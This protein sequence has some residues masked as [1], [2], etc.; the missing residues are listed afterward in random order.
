MVLQRMTSDNVTI[1]T[2]W[3]Y[4][5][6]NTI[7]TAKVSNVLNEFSTTVGDDGKWMVEINEPSLVGSGYSIQIVNQN[8]ERLEERSTTLND[9]AFGDVWFCSG[10][11]NMQWLVK[12]VRNAAMEMETATMYEDIRLLKIVKQAS[13]EPID[14]PLGFSTH[15]AKPE[16][17]FL[18]SESF[19][20]IC[21]FF[22]EQIYDELNVPIG[23]IDASVGGTFIEAWSPPEALAAC[24]VDDDGVGNDKNHNEYLWNA[25]IHPFLNM[26]IKGVL[27]YQGENNAGYSNSNYRGHNRDIYDCTFSNLIT[28]WRQ[29]WHNSDPEFPFGFVQLAPYTDQRTY[30]AWPQLRW[31]QTN[32]ADA[33]NNVFMAT[34][35]DDDFNLHPKNKRLPA[36]RLGWAAA[37]MVYDLQDR[38]LHGPLPSIVSVDNQE[39]I[40]SFSSP[41]SPIVVEDDRFMVCCEATAEECDQLAYGEGWQGVQIVGMVED[42]DTKIKLDLG[43]TCEGRTPSSLAYL[44]LETPC[45]AEESCPLYSSDQYKMPVAPFRLDVTSI[46][47]N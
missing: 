13:T 15:W 19:S 35:V 18:T 33:L 39:V 43:S 2:L 29:N 28:S 1:P 3:G 4:G 10:Q 26:A 24:G 30:L 47:E 37:N 22:G 31:S 12:G 7:V 21:L 38:P 20:A 23:L 42:D 6:P 14:E 44:W 17:E 36:T 5:E 9:V 8:L 34:S 25:M 46:A 16:L 11:S 45:A 32:V 41:I 27:W 40:L